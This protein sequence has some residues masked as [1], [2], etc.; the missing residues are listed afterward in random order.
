MFAPGV[1]GK[2][3][4]IVFKKI[5]CFAMIVVSNVFCKWSKMMVKA[6]GFISSLHP[7]GAKR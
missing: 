4:Y 3:R 2:F 7:L 6:L 5:V 1:A